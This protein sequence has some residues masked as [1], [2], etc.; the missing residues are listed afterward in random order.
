M[1][2]ICHQGQ[3]P[4]SGHIYCYVRTKE[5]EWTKINDNYKT[6]YNDIPKDEPIYGLI[7]EKMLDTSKEDVNQNKSINEKANTVQLQENEKKDTTSTTGNQ[8]KNKDL[9]R[10]PIS[11]HQKYYEKPTG[12]RI[13]DTRK[14]D[15]K[16]YDEHPRNRDGK[17]ED[18]ITTNSQNGEIPS[19]SNSCEYSSV[20]TDNE[21]N[22]KQR[23]LQGVGD[24]E[25]EYAEIYMK[26]L[27]KRRNYDK[28]KEKNRNRLIEK[29]HKKRKDPLDMDFNKPLKK[30]IKNLIQ[31]IYLRIRLPLDF[32]L[33]VN[34]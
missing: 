5:E 6:T 31:K 3:T 28:G 11:K 20:N 33:Q 21:E 25:K 30:K 22:Q 15:K 18:S 32:L 23:I 29:D 7:Y 14:Y 8:A 26:D 34:H 27:V 19:S 2:V 1:A 13:E 12:G 9:Y 10:R 16:K 17:S 24:D 4:N